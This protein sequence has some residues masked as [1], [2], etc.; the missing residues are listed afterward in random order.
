[1]LGSGVHPTQVSMCS[2][3]GAVLVAM[4]VYRLFHKT[5]RGP[6]MGPAPCDSCG[7]AGV[8]ARLASAPDG[9]PTQPIGPVDIDPNGRTMSAGEVKQRLAKSSIIGSGSGFY[10]LE[11]PSNT[12][13]ASE[14]GSNTSIY[15]AL[16]DTL[17]GH[18][19]KKFDPENMMQMSMP[20]GT[21]AL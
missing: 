1:M 14:R 2:I 18:I 5:M 13:K 20:A 10:F 19:E 6:E 12:I 15:G 8:S 17:L 7:S 11:K 16:S 9:A 4:I 21:P 3:L